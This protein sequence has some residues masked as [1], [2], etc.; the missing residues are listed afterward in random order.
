[1]TAVAEP[2][3]E[4]P[5]PAAVRS[6]VPAEEPESSP[7]RRDLSAASVARTVLLWALVALASIALILYLVEPLF[8]QRTQHA[9]LSKMRGEISHAHYELQGLPGSTN[10]AAAP[11]LGA[12]V[13]VLEIPQLKLRQAVVEGVAP[14]QT[15]AGPGHVPGTAGPGQPG[16]S[17]IVGRRST[18]GGPFR[19]LGDLRRGDRILVTTTQGQTVYSVKSTRRMT[20]SSGSSSSS[21]SSG[22]GSTN[23]TTAPIPGALTNTPTVPQVDVDDLYGPTK[24]DQLTLVTSSSSW[25]ANTS[26]ATVVVATMKT[27]P[28]V[29]TAQ[30]GRNSNQTGLT[31]DT[32]G[33][34]GLLLAF[35]GF[36]LAGLAAGYLNRRAGPRVAYLLTTPP[37]IVFVILMAEASSRLLPA[38]F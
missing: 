36:V 12:P 17:V 26:D 38:W 28:F 3:V 7:A 32:S 23:V 18:Y 35:Q 15:A 29:P 4:A 24:T 31:G 34:A 19:S 6:D 37:L 2:V 8:Q 13:A 20:I 5:E 16:N 11:S 27:T 9:L 14:S 25:P 1:V 10:V 33:W 30:N 22:L 21:S